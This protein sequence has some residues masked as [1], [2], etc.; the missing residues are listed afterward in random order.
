M[1]DELNADRPRRRWHDNRGDLTLM[2]DLLEHI[3]EEVIP[4]IADGL[5][6]KANKDFQ[7]SEILS[8]LKSLGKDKIMALHQSKK[9][10]RSYDK[11]PNLHNIMTHFFVL[12]DKIQDVLA[13]QF[14]MF[15]E[16]IVDY[17]AVCDSFGLEPQ[18]EELRR[19]RDLFVEHGADAVDAYLA[20]IHKPYLDKLMAE[21]SED[22]LPKEQIAEDQ[23]GMKIRG[24][25]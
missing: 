16:R 8:S 12:P 22:A 17:L 19:M 18:Q 24:E 5:T 1:T 13:S 2:V 10:Q 23:G 4:L 7:A 20:K 9:K 15:T 14:L 3:P 11:D 6:A 25:F 21:E